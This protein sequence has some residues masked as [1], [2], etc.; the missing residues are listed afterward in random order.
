M[1][2]ITLL[3]A[4][5]F[6]A[7]LASAEPMVLSL[8]GALRNAREN[9]SG[10]KAAQVTLDL[11]DREAATAWNVFLPSLSVSGRLTNTQALPGSD[12]EIDPDMATSLTVSGSAS[13]SLQGG[14]GETLRQK[15]LAKQS[16]LATYKKAQADLAIQ[17][18]K[19]Y[20][21]LVTQRKSLE[22]SQ[23]NLDLAKEQERRVMANYQ[24]GLV[25]E[26]DYLSAQYT[27]AGLESDLL[28]L[29]QTAASAVK[30]FNILL[31]LPMDTEIELTDAIATDIP[32]VKRPESLDEYVE[33]RNDV[34]VAYYALQT[35]KSQ[36][37]ASRISRY[38]P[39]LSLSESV[40]AS[41]TPPKDLEKPQTGSLTLS[42]TLPLDGYVPGSSASLTEKK[43]AG[44]V[45]KA[46][47]ALADVRTAARQEIESLFDSLDQLS[48]TVRL[49]Q[50]NEKISLRKYE[51]SKQGYDSG[52]VTQGD[53][54]DARQN[55][56]SAQL[57][58]LSAQNALEQGF[59]NLA[60][61]M[62][63]EET[64]LYGKEN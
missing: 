32:S 5:A 63:V 17:V 18:K 43:A 13:V 40:S 20:F 4:L 21:N 12:I 64:S 48:E 33:R 36:L 23:R 26:L 16:A 28:S 62:N 8:D 39:T 30:A 25:S 60:N 2:K 31:G 38:G 1:R 46:Q 54:D 52:L 9:N 14:L 27:R 11:T 19:G 34:A 56:L 61:A 45:E 58:V 53:L 35:A 7:A 47:L 10:L 42:V 6:V 29:K 57:K 37:T 41:A 55:Y 15:S 50:F 3:F 49:T 24:N 59:I 44:A 51:L 22:V